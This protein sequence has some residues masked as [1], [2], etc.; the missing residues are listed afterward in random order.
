MIDPP[1]GSAPSPSSAPADS[2]SPD[3]RRAG[4]GWGRAIASAVAIVVIA[5]VGA[6]W[7]PDFLLRELS[8]VGRDT[9]VLIASTISVMLVVVIAWGLRR[10][11]ATGR[12]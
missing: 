10:L 6:I 4:I 1:T 3:A 11:Q 12:I 8:T 7:L 9:R 5:F 2:R